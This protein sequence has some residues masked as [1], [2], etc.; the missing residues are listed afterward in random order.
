[1]QFLCNSEA[2]T[3]RNVDFG[4]RLASVDPMHPRELAISSLLIIS[5]M[6]K[7]LPVLLAHILLIHAH[8]E[9]ELNFKRLSP[10]FLADCFSL[11]FYP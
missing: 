2:S 11:G 6:Y 9:G 3:C 10:I 5:K 8:A 7:F 4:M 1:L